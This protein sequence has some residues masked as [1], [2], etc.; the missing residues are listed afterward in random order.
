MTDSHSSTHFFPLHPPE[1]EPH[2]ANL[3]GPRTQLLHAGSSDRPSLTSELLLSR[4]HWSRAGGPRH[5]ACTNRS[6]ATRSPCA[7]PRSPPGPAP[8]SLCDPPGT[9]VLRKRYTS[10]SPPGLVRCRARVERMESAQH[11]ALKMGARGLGLGGW[12]MPSC[13]G[14]PFFL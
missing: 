10:T 2:L 11:V 6:W 5:A 14:M 4:L 9:W 3:P 7:V 8:R 13:I 1:K 12:R